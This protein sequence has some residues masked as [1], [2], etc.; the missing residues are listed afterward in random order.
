MTNCNYILTNHEEASVPE[1]IIA[2]CLLEEGHDAEH[3]CSFIDHLGTRKFL[4][5]VRDDD[6]GC[7]TPSNYGGQWC[8]CVISNYVTRSEAR[9]I[10]LDAGR[11]CP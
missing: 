1:G 10:L 11:D 4:Q 6:C 2:E 9:Q 8:G 5:W 3:L 7:S